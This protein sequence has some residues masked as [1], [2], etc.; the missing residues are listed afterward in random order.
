LFLLLP[1]IHS[2]DISDHIFAHKLC[3]S[4]LKEHPQYIDI[5]DSWNHH[6]FAIKKF[7]R[8]LHRNKILGRETTI[9]EKDFLLRPSSSF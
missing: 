8:Y 3:E 7:G 1:L 4:Y 6:T 2:E 5:K 9:E